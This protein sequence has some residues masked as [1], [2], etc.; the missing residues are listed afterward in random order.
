MRTLAKIVYSLN[1]RYTYEQSE[2]F[3]A[4]LL[5]NADPVYPKRKDIES[6]IVTADIIET[7]KISRV[8][9]NSLKHPNI[10]T[11]SGTQK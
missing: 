6:K 5:H 1:V 4:Q 11:R 9:M 2:T 10:N 8:D 3:R 7:K